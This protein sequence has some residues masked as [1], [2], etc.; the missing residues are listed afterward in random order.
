MK[1]LPETSDCLGQNEDNKNVILK[2]KNSKNKA[3]ILHRKSSPK[4]KQTLF[5]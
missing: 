4:S 3:E 5:P 2:K 1:F